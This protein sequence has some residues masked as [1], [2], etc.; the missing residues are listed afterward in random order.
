MIILHTSILT[1]YIEVDFIGIVIGTLVYGYRKSEHKK[2]IQIYIAP[3]L[4]EKSKISGRAMDDDE[5]DTSLSGASIDCFSQE[6]EE[7]DCCAQNSSCVVSPWGQRDCRYISL[8]K[9]MIMSIRKTIRTAG[10]WVTH[11]LHFI[12]SLNV[13]QG[14]YVVRDVWV[15]TR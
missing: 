15:E 12:L 14:A 11:Q 3:V 1:A 9:G 2:S 5:I 6:C 4:D 8:D 7:C 10:K 13:C